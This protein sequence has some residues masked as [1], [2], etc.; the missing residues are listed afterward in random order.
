M[1]ENNRLPMD[2]IS[3][4]TEA[5]EQKE[6][7]ENLQEEPDG[8]TGYSRAREIYE[9][10]SSIA[11]AVVL[12]LVIN[13]FFFAFVQVDG[14]SMEPTLYHN[15]RLVVRKIFYTPEQKDIVIVKSGALQKYIVKR[16]IALPGQTV[17]FD[18][19]RNMVVDG[20][21]LDEPYIKEK[22]V[23]FGNLYTYPVVVPKKGEV[24]R[25]PYLM[26]EA[27]LKAGRNGMS[28]AL[29]DDGTI[30][31][32]G[33]ELVEDGIF[34]EGQT[35]YKQDCYFVMGD[36]RN[37]SSDSRSLGLIPESEVIGKSTLRLFPFDKIGFVG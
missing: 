5:I 16:V 13:Q 27:Q 20:V 22:Q 32:R 7:N 30:L 28:L 35:T 1:D 15:E 25:F 3:E 4:E 19:N 37:H 24:A 12:A 2:E 34:V 26:A 11:I 33:S 36:N 8:K 23:S 29:Q 10:I 6:I 17:T 21:V 31:V 9:W 14:Q 18:E